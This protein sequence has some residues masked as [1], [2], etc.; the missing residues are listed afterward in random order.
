MPQPGDRETRFVTDLRRLTEPTVDRATLAALRRA[1]DTPVGA[2][3]P[4]VHRF[5]APRTSGLSLQRE[6][7]FY[8]VASLFADHHQIDWPH[9]G[10]DGPH[11]ASGLGASFARLARDP[12]VG[13][14]AE[15]RFSE[16]LGSD[17]DQLSTHLRHAISLLKAHSIPVDWAQLL[18]DIG[19][20]DWES[21]TVQRTWARDFWGAQ[22]TA[23]DS[24]AT[25]TLAEA[26]DPAAAVHDHL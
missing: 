13:G 6:N 4:A 2:A 19:R 8:L 14:G 1:A 11:R 5:V 24:A 17:R 7:D 25:D 16:V 21:R 22:E 12:Q 23:P 18:S 20:W 15:R 3:L 10:D 26:A 9:K